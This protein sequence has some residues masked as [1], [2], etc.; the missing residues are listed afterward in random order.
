[1]FLRPAAHPGGGGRV[2]DGE[3]FELPEGDIRERGGD[4][5]GALEVCGLH[6]LVPCFVGHVDA[7]GVAVE[8]L[9]VLVDD[10]HGEL[11]KRA[12][13]E[14]GAGVVRNDV[15]CRHS[16]L[17]RARE[18][19]PSRQAREGSQEGPMGT[20]ASLAAASC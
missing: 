15:L 2:R 13:G 6:H 4:G 19:P 1:M 3:L 5:V 12:Q 17:N 18:F 9:G 10:H 7:V 14:S 11:G 8:D 20:V 16:A